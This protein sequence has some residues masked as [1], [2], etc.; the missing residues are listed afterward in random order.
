[1]FSGRLANSAIAT[2]CE[3]DSLDADGEWKAL[4]GSAKLAL[5]S[6]NT[7]ELFLRAA[8]AYAE[9]QGWPRKKTLPHNC[10][11]KGLFV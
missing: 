4:S 8:E 3:Q 5:I 11:A 10:L 6:P 7:E 2:K 9:L 1:M